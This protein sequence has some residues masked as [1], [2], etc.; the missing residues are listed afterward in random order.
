[1]KAKLFIGPMSKNV[2]DAIIDYA[3]NNNAEIGIMNLQN[4]IA[5]TRIIMR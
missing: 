4:F 2:V 5:H 3:N 1:M